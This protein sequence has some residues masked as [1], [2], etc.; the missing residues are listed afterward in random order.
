MDFYL[1]KITISRKVTQEYIFHIKNFWGKIGISTD[2][3][4]PPTFVDNY[5]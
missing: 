5:F 2:V 4:L 3:N 1:E